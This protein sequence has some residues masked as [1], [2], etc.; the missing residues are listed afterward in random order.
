MKPI[1]RQRDQDH[2]LVRV[3]RRRA[4]DAGDLEA[5]TAL[6]LG[7]DLD[8]HRELVVP[9][10]RE[11]IGTGGPRRCQRRGPSSERELRRDEER[12]SLPSCSSPTRHRRARVYRDAALSRSS[13]IERDDLAHVAFSAIGAMVAGGV[14]RFGE[15]SALAGAED[16]PVPRVQLYVWRNRGRPHARGQGAATP[17]RRT[18]SGDRYRRPSRCRCGGDIGGRRLDRGAAAR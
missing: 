7:L 11:Q 16:A 9:D 1:G 3:R 2:P 4:A 12:A 15:A 10:L 17:L 13:D 14:G 8:R 6:A 18:A 5:A